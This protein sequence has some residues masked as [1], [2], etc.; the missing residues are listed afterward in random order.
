LAD[1][2]ATTPFNPSAGLKCDRNST[3]LFSLRS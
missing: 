2:P 1:P 3:L